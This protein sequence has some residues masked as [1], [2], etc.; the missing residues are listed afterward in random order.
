VN[1]ILEA[2]EDAGGH[3]GWTTASAIAYEYDGRGVASGTWARNLWRLESAG[4]LETK[5]V[6]GRN[7]WCLTAAGEERL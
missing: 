6:G 3:G 1:R 2:V 5:V 4:L 7:L